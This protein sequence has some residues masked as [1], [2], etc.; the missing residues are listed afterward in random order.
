MDHGQ[1]AFLRELLASSETMEQTRRFARTLRT[2]ARD[3]LLLLGAPDGEEPWHLAAHL[4]EESRFVP[5]LKPTL[6]RWQP[7]PG[8]PP[9]LAIGLDRL[10]DARRGEALFVVSEAAAAPAPLL[11]R[12]D[13]ARRTGAV[14]LTLDGGDRELTGLAHEALTVPPAGPVT[15]EQA[16]HLV[17]AVAGEEGG[18]RGLRDR[19]ARFL[20]LV[21]GPQEP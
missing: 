15:F 12:V 17:S 8:A 14:I 3:D 5:S 21:A 4:D 19:L 9:H 1:V 10:A 20:D 13:D 7:P 16:Q 6:V 2:S 11:E 18:R